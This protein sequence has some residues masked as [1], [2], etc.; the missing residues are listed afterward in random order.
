RV[1]LGK[2]A[3]PEAPIPT[4]KYVLW[5]LT[6]G[7]ADPRPPFAVPT[8]PPP[9]MTFASLRPG[10]LLEGQVTRAV[11]FGVFVDVGL[12]VEALVPLPHLGDRPGTDPATI[13]PVGAVIHGRVLE[14]DVPKRRITLSMRTDRE[15]RREGPP[16]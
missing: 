6:T 3:R 15:E 4:L 12:G 5:Q 2:L 10:L 16:R 7:L 13:A 11:P 8:K 1:D 14:I 9:E